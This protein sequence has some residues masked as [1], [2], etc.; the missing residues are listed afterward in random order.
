VHPILHKIFLGFIP[1]GPTDKASA[2]GAEDSR[3]DPWCGSPHFPLGTTLRFFAAQAS[4]RLWHGKKSLAKS[5]PIL[6]FFGLPHKQAND[7]DMARNLRQKAFRMNREIGPV[8]AKCWTST[9]GIEP[10]IFRSVGGRLIH[11]AMRN[12]AQEDYG[13]SDDFMIKIL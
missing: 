1:H 2:Y 4:K 10:G 6:R 9:P 3:F 12:E 11:W 8:E 13:G 7:F 5:F